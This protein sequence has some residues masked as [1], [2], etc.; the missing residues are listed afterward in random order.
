[1]TIRSLVT[2]LF[3]LGYSL[4]YLAQTTSVEGRIFDGETGKPL[5]FVTVSFNGISEGTTSDI[6][7]RY[8]L[9]T[10]ERV[11]RIHISFLGY[12][13]QTIQIQKEVHQTLDVALEP[14]RIE[15]AVA[16]V[17]PDRKRK[18]P[19]KPLMQRVA[20]AK[21]SNNSKNIP[22]LK[23][24]FHDR[25]E[26]DVNDI[27]EKLP[28]RKFWGAFGWVWDKLDS[29]EQ[30]V[31]LPLFMSESTGLIRTQN[32]PSR[33]EKRIEAARATWMEEG[34]NS[35]SVS[36]EFFDIDIYE[37]QFLLLDKAFTSPI[38]DRGNLHY[39][40]YILDT[41]EVEGRVN[42][43]LAF[44]P[45]RR[46][47]YTFEGEFWI[48]T[49]TMGLSKID[50]KISEGAAIN[51]IRS[52]GFMQM[53]DFQNENWVL[54]KREIIIDA[55]LV[56]R[57]M[58]VYARN[59]TLYYDFEFAEEWPN[60]VWGSKRDLTYDIGAHD[61]LE[62]EW[63][64]KRPHP[65][66]SREM[67]IYETVDSI[68]SMPQFDFFGSLIYFIGTGY[69][70]FEHI[71]IGPWYDA[72]SYNEVEGNRFS[73][74]M[75]TTDEVSKKI[76]P[77]VFCAYGNRDREFKY[78]ADITYVQKRV[79]RIEW[80]ASYQKDIEQLGM[81]G[82][83]DQGN[84]FNS[85]FNLRA[86]NQLAMISMAEASFLG[87]FGSGFTSYIELRHRK[88]ESRGKLDFLS[89]NYVVRSPGGPAWTAERPSIITAESTFQLRYAKNE[90][91][92]SGSTE[93]ISLGT[94]APIWTLTT[95]QGWKGIAGSQYRYGRY[96][97]GLEGKLRLGPLGRIDYNS[98]IGTYSGKAPFPLLELQPAN[99]TVLSIKES[100]NLLQYFEYVTDTWARGF[101]EWHGEGLV[102]GRIPW[103]KQLELR[104]LIGIK[105]VYGRWDDR[106]ESILELPESTNGL[107]GFY[108][109]AVIGIENILGL[110][111]VD[112]NLQLKEP[113]I[114]FSEKWGIRVGLGF[115][116]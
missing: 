77:S 15:L 54:S 7:G 42:F 33:T 56:G 60:E 100:F 105:G 103:I 107:N 46:G 98:E 16:E 70:E 12:L 5:P 49:L 52:M 72:Y 109:E 85:A 44:V 89:P 65:L 116:L 74:E 18:N 41:L 24:K 78:R 34:D 111:R 101:Y 8:A 61:V 90:K 73:L 84:L 22:A 55:S 37:N 69:V 82:F 66:S 71:E 94:R 113:T 93:R 91:F 20:D 4:L 108:G 68:Q 95:T 31:N 114:D 64:K 2:L 86:Q 21:K 47:E 11:G 35:T 30:R 1:M 9:S 6:D 25:L 3:C 110:M 39:R 26:V 38:H 96:T 97:L 57:S 104:E 102:L 115:E 76:F 17:R 83:F 81:M 53:Y 10:N 79:P 48:D 63:V 13:S 23:F 36:A 28:A 43:H 80:Y 99:E 59:K 27:P 51:F 50:A 14:K 87:E 106:H 75:Y 67:D 32:K 40:Y 112:F 58:G 19:A 29:S 62:Q 45:R 88:V 92:V